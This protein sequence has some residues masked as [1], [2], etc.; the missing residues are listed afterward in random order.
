MQSFKFAL[1][2]DEDGLIPEV[3]VLVQAFY[4][5]LRGFKHFRR[6]YRVHATDNVPVTW[7]VMLCDELFD[8]IEGGKLETGNLD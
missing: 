7:D 8:E 3:R 6:E 5:L 1:I 2:P 4:T